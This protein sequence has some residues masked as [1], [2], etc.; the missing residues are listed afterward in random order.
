MKIFLDGSFNVWTDVVLLD[1]QVWA[2]IIE[3]WSHVGLITSFK[4]RC[5]RS[6]IAFSNEVTDRL[7]EYM[8]QS[9]NVLCSPLDIGEAILNTWEQN[10]HVLHGIRDTWLFSP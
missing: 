6:H 2:V 3:V 7:S 4:Y 8:S 9:W 1:R 5:L 10:M